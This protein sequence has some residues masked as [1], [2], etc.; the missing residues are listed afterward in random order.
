MKQATPTSA[1]AKRQWQP[2]IDEAEDR[3]HHRRQQELR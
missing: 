2:G 3:R 1:K